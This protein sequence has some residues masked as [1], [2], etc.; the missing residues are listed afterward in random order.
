MSPLGP[1]GVTDCLT[2]A[3]RAEFLCCSVSQLKSELRDRS[4]WHKEISTPF[5]ALGVPDTV[6]RVMIKLS[7]ENGTS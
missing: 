5:T 1:A 4:S 6:M 2:W 7:L 3:L